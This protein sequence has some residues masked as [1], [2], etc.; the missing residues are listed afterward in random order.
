MR[1]IRIGPSEVGTREGKEEDDEREGLTDRESLWKRGRETGREEME[2]C[3]G[4][5]EK[6]R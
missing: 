2:L 1:K 4:R 6:R 3:D 5:S